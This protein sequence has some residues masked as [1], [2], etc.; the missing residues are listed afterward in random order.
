MQG[1][2]YKLLQSSKQAAQLV[3]RPSKQASIRRCRIDRSETVCGDGWTGGEFAIRRVLVFGTRDD[4][5]RPGTLDAMVVDGRALSD[6]ADDRGR[7]WRTR[8]KALSF[9][10]YTDAVRVTLSDLRDM[11]DPIPLVLYY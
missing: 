3:L 7:T 8:K 1:K 4:D 11:C 2:K 10:F 6:K 9:Y 5:T